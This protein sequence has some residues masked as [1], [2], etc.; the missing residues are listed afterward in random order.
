MTPPS[1]YKVELRCSSGA[2]LGA[3]PFDT[4]AVKARSGGEPSTVREPANGQT[5]RP[6]EVAGSSEGH[7]LDPHDITPCLQGATA[8]ITLP[9]LWS[10]DDAT[11]LLEWFAALYSRED[12]GASL[13]LPASFSKDDRKAGIAR[14]C[15]SLPP[16]D[17]LRPL[18]GCV[19][20]GVAQ[21]RRG[22]PPSQ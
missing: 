8:S 10:N 2:D 3:C 5:Q 19:P 4:V 13:S 16:L 20:R 6:P 14:S 7:S 1:V 9:R 22:A 11:E 17:H 15:P 21:A 18:G 12:A